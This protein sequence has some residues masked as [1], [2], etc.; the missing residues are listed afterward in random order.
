MSIRQI[1]DFNTRICYIIRQIV[2]GACEI[3]KSPEFVE[4]LAGVGLLIITANG[5]FL[6]IEEARTNRRTAKIKGMRSLPMETIES[7]ETHKKALKRLLKEEVSTENLSGHTDPTKLC[8]V[9]LTPGVWLHAYLIPV[10]CIFQAEAGTH[11]DALNPKWVHINEVLNSDPKDRRFRPGTRE[12]L[13]SYLEF[14]QNNTFQP[15]LYFRCGDEIPQEVFDELD[16]I[17]Q[18]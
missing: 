10:N 6:S 3:D 1:L 9:Q 5:Y 13:K 7:G 14:H 2:E 12:V 16:S 18:A 4:T 17:S 15:G 8:R 11:K